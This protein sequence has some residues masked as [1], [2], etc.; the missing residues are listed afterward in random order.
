MP[1]YADKKRSFLKAAQPGDIVGVRGEDWQGKIIRWVT[2]SEISHVA[3]YIGN[4]LIIESTLGPGVRILPIDVYLSDQNKEVYLARIIEK[5]DANEVIDYAY[6]FYGRKY[7]LLG[8]IGI[9]TKYL[10]KKVNLNKVITFW[11]KN[12]V[13]DE[14][15]VW[16]S[17]FLGDIFAPKKIMFIDEDTTYLTPGEIFYS[18]IVNQVRYNDIL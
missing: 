14:Y 16:C 4:G 13:N 17:E 2:D 9:M 10:V 11:G 1:S 18:P 6:N 5:F 12:K 15:G 3:L 7:D 8:Q